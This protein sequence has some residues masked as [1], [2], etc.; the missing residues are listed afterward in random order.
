MEKQLSLLNPTWLKRSFRL[1][2]YF[3]VLV[4]FFN[5][6]NLIHSLNFTSITALG[7]NQASCEPSLL[8][9][10]HFKDRAH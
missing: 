3:Y 7:S 5:Y 10:T 1:G 9:I 2:K 8:Q 4:W 6:C